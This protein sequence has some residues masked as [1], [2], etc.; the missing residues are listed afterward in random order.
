MAYKLKSMQ[1]NKCEALSIDEKNDNTVTEGYISSQQLQEE[2]KKAGKAT[3]SYIESLK[4]SLSNEDYI[5]QKEQIE[6]EEFRNQLRKASE[7]AKE[8]I[9]QIFERSRLSKSLREQAINIENLKNKFNQ[10]YEKFIKDNQ[11]KTIQNLKKEL[12]EA[13]KNNNK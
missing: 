8:K 5:A 2:L 4:A 11:E 13:K 10:E 9:N 1:G 12:E 3:T 7:D 6:S